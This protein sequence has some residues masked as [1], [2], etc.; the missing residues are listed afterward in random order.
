M[1]RTDRQLSREEAE[2]ILRENQYGVLSTVCADGRPYGLPISYAYAGGKLYFH[3]TAA[4]SLLRENIGGQARACFT[5]V[6]KTRLLP[7]KF[8]TQY[9]S[10]IAF[11][12]IRESEDKTEGLLR[13]VEALS[14][15]FME[16]GRRYAAAAQDRVVVYEFEIEE[17]TGKARRED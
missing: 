10:A 13:L 12:I 3:H 8:S 4:E 14:P 6:G 11:G 2:Q 1:R 7:E 5:V 9:E 15:A 16:Q 17:L